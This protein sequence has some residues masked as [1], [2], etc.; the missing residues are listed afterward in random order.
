LIIPTASSF[1]VFWMTLYIRNSVPGELLDAARIDGCSDTKTFVQIVIPVIKPAIGTLSLLTFLGSWNNF[2]LPLIILNEPE[3][4]TLPVGI[5]SFGNMYRL[6]LGVQIA[7]L[8]LATFPILIV[9]A[10][11]NKSL[12]RGITAGAVKG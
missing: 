6:D 10:L 7:A 8:T 11:F 1:G 2:M 3:L 12:I 9:F 4:Y 5:K